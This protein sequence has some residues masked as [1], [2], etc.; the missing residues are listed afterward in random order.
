MVVGLVST[1][2]KAFGWNCTKTGP[3]GLI[4]SCF[5][6]INLSLKE[7]FVLDLIMQITNI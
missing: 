7:D 1:T 3:C 4:M 5:P 6:L 2:S